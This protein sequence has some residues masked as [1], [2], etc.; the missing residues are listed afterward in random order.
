MRSVLF[1]A[2][3]IRAFEPY[4]EY[5][6]RELPD[7]TGYAQEAA[8]REMKKL[9]SKL[10]TRGINVEAAV[11]LAGRQKKFATTRASAMSI[12]SLLQRTAALGSSTW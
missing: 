8:K 10:R 1:N 7:V 9:I 5:R 3:P 11:E 6:G 4:G 2:V 12:L